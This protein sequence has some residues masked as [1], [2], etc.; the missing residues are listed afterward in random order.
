MKRVPIVPVAGAAL[1]L[2]P[3]LAAS[4]AF[5]RGGAIKMLVLELLFVVVSVALGVVYAI[6]HPD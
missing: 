4:P 6:G 2:V 5:I 3:L 1:M